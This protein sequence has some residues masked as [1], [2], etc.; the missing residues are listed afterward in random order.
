MVRIHSIRI[1]SSALP[2]LYGQLAPDHPRA[3]SLDISA[4]LILAIVLRYGGTSWAQLGAF[5]FVALMN[6]RRGGPLGAALRSEFCS[7]LS[8]SSFHAALLA[9]SSR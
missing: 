4:Q 9:Q 6:S 7:S 8:S 2:G 3:A 5:A 1:F